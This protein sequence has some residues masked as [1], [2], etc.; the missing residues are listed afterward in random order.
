MLIFTQRCVQNATISLSQH[1]VIPYFECKQITEKGLDINPTQ[2][3]EYFY[4]ISSGYLERVG[5]LE[6]EQVRFG[7]WKKIKK[8]SEYEMHSHQGP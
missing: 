2:E 8:D 4:Q 6:S 3:N 5:T 7:S 1:T